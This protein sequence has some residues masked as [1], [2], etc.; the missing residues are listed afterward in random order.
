M[1]LIVLLLITSETFTVPKGDGY[2]Y[3]DPD[4]PGNESKT[5]DR[6]RASYKADGNTITFQLELL[7]VPQKLTYQYAFVNGFLE[8]I[9]KEIHN[10]L[11]GAP[12][13]HK[14]VWTLQK[15]N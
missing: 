10:E 14:E 4:K 11:E 6:L 8:L 9:V 15:I 5:T 7:P 3:A 2:L 12:M 1:P 13:I